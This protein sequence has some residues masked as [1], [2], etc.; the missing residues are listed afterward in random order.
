MFGRVGVKAADFGVNDIGSLFHFSAFKEGGAHSY[1]RKRSVAS[2]MIGV[3]DGGLIAPIPFGNDFL[4]AAWG[5]ISRAGHVDE[6]IRRFNSFREVL[7][8]DGID[9]PLENFCTNRE[10][11]PRWRFIEPVDLHLIPIPMEKIGKYVAPFFY[12]VRLAPDVPE[13][14]FDGGAEFLIPFR[15]DMSID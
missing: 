2:H 3:S 5:N 6:I 4:S 12:P 15:F 9:F 13:L 10:I 8:K 11:F 14:F 7:L 1:G